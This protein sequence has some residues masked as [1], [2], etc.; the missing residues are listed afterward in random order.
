VLARFKAKHPNDWALL[1]EKAIFQMND[2]HPT[3]AVAELMRLLID[4]EGLDW[5]TAWGITLKVIKSSWVAMISWKLNVERQEH[6]W[7]CTCI[8]QQMKICAAITHCQSLLQYSEYRLGAAACC[9]RQ[10][11]A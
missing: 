6:A 9:R 3:I 8:S 2:T 1:P 11:C 10:A 4:Q 7:F 5:D